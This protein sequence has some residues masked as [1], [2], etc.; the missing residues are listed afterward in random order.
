MDWFVSHYLWL[1]SKFFFITNIY[2]WLYAVPVMISSLSWMTTICLW[3]GWCFSW[4]KR[5]RCSPQSVKNYCIFVLNSSHFLCPSHR[6]ITGVHASAARLCQHD[7]V[8]EEGTLCRHGFRCGWT[9]RHHRSQWWRGGVLI[10]SHAHTTPCL[11]PV[12]YIE[13]C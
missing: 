2:V 6:A 12:F 10:Q 8:G 4:Q 7:N 11:V 3:S 1:A 9:L 5:G 13:L